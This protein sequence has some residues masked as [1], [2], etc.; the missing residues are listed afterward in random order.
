MPQSG[1]AQAFNA[2]DFEAWSTN[3]RVAHDKLF[4]A[5]TCV[6]ALSARYHATSSRYERALLADELRNHRTLL[7]A[8]GYDGVVSSVSSDGGA[9]SGDGDGDREGS[10]SMDEDAMAGAGVALHMQAAQHKGG[11]AVDDI[12]AMLVSPL[13]DAYWT[14]LFPVQCVWYQPITCRSNTPMYYG[15]SNAV[16]C[17]AVF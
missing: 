5:P 13:H 17:A 7:C 8:P 15:H 6:R 12:R 10:H 14:C 3:Y 9:A 16:W 2:T 11:V 1:L 4:S